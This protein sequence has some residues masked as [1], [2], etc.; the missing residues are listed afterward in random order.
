M[1]MMILILITIIM[2]IM[3]IMIMIMMLV[4]CVKCT[5][6]LCI[7]VIVIDYNYEELGMV[8]MDTLKVSPSTAKAFDWEICEVDVSEAYIRSVSNYLCI[9]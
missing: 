6:A 1:T 4:W 3:T 9:S 2:I 5:R 7:G 8:H